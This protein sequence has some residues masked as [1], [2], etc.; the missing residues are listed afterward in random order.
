MASK[1]TAKKVRCWAVYRKAGR[2]TMPSMK[3]AGIRFLVSPGG[4]SAAAVRD[5]V[6][7]VNEAITGHVPCAPR[8]KPRAVTKGAK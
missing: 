2:Y 8:R 1:A 5:A 6:R 4:F 3:L 7:K